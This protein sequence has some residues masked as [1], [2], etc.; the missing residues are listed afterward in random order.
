MSKRGR[1]DNS[2]GMDKLDIAIYGLGHDHPGGVP[3]LAKKINVRAGVL[4]NKLDPFMESHRPNIQEVRAAMLAQGDF[5]ILDAL[6][7]DCGFILVPLDKYMQPVGDAGLLERYA[8]ADATRGLFSQ[9]LAKALEDQ[10]ITKTEAKRLRKVLRQE[11]SD[12]ESLMLG[13]ERL[14]Q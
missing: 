14:S 3:A 4:Q 9:Q 1:F 5:R 6:A 2:H 11:Q 13:L 7:E 10:V 8:K 12:L